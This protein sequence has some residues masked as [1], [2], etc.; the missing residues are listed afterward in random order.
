MNIWKDLYTKLHLLLAVVEGEGFQV[1]ANKKQMYGNVFD[2][3][4]SQQIEAMIMANNFYLSIFY[5]EVPGAIQLQNAIIRKDKFPVYTITWNPKSL[6]NYADYVI[7]HLGNGAS[8]YRCQA[9]SDFKTLSN[10]LSGNFKNDY[11]MENMRGSNMFNHHITD[12][13]YKNIAQSQNYPNYTFPTFISLCNDLKFNIDPSQMFYGRGTDPQIKN[14]VSIL[15]KVEHSPIYPFDNYPQENHYFTRS[16]FIPKESVNFYTNLLS[17]IN[18]KCETTIQTGPNEIAPNDD[19][20]QSLVAYADSFQL[21][22]SVYSTRHDDKFKNEKPKL[23]TRRR[24][25]SMSYPF[26]DTLLFRNKSFE[27]LSYNNSK[28]ESNESSKKRCLSM[29]GEINNVPYK[30]YVVSSVDPQFCFSTTKMMPSLNQPQSSQPFD[31]YTSTTGGASVE[32]GYSTDTDLNAESYDFKTQDDDYFNIHTT[33]NID[34]LNKAYIQQ[35]NVFSNMGNTIHMMPDYDPIIKIDNDLTCINLPQQQ[36][37]QQQQEPLSS[38][39]NNNTQQQNVSDSLEDKQDS[40][41]SSAIVI[42]KSTKDYVMK[43]EV[44]IR[45]LR[46]PTPPPSGPIVIREVREKPKRI[47][48]PIIIQENKCINSKTPS[49][50]IFRERPPE[51]PEVKGT[52]II[53]KRIPS[54]RNPS[55]QIII[56]RLPILPIRKPPPIVIERWL[57]YPEQKRKVIYEKAS[58]IPKKRRSKK[59]IIEY[60]NMNVI[61]DKVVK[62]I[63]G[64]NK[65]DPVRYIKQY[66][67]TLHSNESLNELLKNVVETSNC[68]KKVNEQNANQKT[69]DHRFSNKGHSITMK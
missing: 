27:D 21:D 60:K 11:Q 44:A 16:S 19:L 50:I 61:V 63:D 35:L 25:Q 4:I 8:F 46:P 31:D 39:I 10:H 6:I 32:W 52:H 29:E 9:L 64:I 15:M 7:Q 3:L 23:S 62:H 41:E 13:N 47:A 49:P 67:G 38:W 40:D 65:T 18:L 68:T 58:P 66:G 1:K 69:N 34:Q 14:D 5:P 51:P 26:E 28:K 37:Q 42:H 30:Q 53:Y 59:V 22:S 56:E 2:D 45:L 36:Q 17:P 48:S 55:P 24:A 43:Q 54:T 33:S 20:L 57:P 12:N